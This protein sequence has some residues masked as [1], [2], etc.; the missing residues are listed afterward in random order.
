MVQQGFHQLNKLKHRW[1]M[2]LKS[3][4]ITF[5]VSMVPLKKAQTFCKLL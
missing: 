2:T 1:V 3:E 4:Y 5:C